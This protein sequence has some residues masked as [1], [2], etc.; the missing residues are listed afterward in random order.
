[1]FS[2]EG[3]RRGKVRAVTGSNEGGMKVVFS[4]EGGRRGKVR[5][6]RSSN[7]GGSRVE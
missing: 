1:M 2:N 6:V 3:G 7:E 5:T 4:N